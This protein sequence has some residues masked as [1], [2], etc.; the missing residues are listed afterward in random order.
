[1]RN[2]LP[3]LPLGK[4]KKEREMKKTYN[5]LV[6]DKIP[7]IIK[8]TGARCEYHV[9]TGEDLKQALYNKLTEEINEFIEDPCIEEMADIQEVLWAIQEYFNLSEY[10]ILTAVHSKAEKR[11]RFEEGYILESVEE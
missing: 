1:M 9:A 6:R 4:S 8:E 2:R 3:P 7:E 10:E 11:G 5:K